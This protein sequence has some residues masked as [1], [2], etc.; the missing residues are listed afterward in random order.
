MTTASTVC[1]VM[2]PSTSVMSTTTSLP[3]VTDPDE[4]V[5]RHE[6]RAAE[7]VFETERL[8]VRPWTQDDADRHFD[9]YSRHEVARW[10][11][12]D[13]GP[14]RPAATSQW[15]G[16]SGGRASQ[17]RQP[18]RASG[19][20][21][22]PRTAIVA[23]TVLLVPIP[24][25]GE[26]Q[27]RP[28]EEGGDVEVGWHLHPDSWG[29]GY[30]TEA[31]QRCAGEG[32]VRRARRGRRSRLRRQRTIAAR[33]P[34]ARHGAERVQPR[35][36]TESSSSRS[37]SVDQPDAQPAETLAL[38]LD[39]D[40]LD[41]PD[42]TRSTRRACRRRPGCRGRRCR[43][44]ARPRARAA[45]GWS[46][47]GSGRDGVA[48]ASSRGR[49]LTS[50]ARSAATSTAQ[51]SA[52][53]S[54][55][56]SGTSGRLKSIRASSGSMLPP[57]TSDAEVAEDDAGQQVQ[58]GVRAHQRR[59]PLVLDR[60]ADGGARPAGSGSPSAGSSTRSSPL[61][62]PT[63]RVCTPPQSSTPWSGGWPPPPG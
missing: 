8:I 50:I 48:K 9:M 29:H 18:V 53:R 16:S 43:R 17:T 26:D 14:A 54:L 15:P 62:T 2:S 20:S 28:P 31:A 46:R 22:S 32:V 42:L 36:G 58:T 61:R 49:L 13:A 37:G 3:H 57:V 6:P 23:G 60:A 38:V 10:L 52:T 35:S 55:K 30:A 63:I 11:G 24:L 44:C 1:S 41:A 51:A 27:P 56:P 33:V 19:R 40:H 4:T 25:T 39:L 59:T 7:P 12:S 5:A 34:A 21:R 45:A 47:Y